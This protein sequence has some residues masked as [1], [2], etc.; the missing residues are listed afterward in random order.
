MSLQ[1]RFLLF[2][3]NCQCP[4]AKDH[5]NT[6]VV[7][8]VAFIIHCG[9]REGTPWGTTEE[10]QEA[11]VEKTCYRIPVALGKLVEDLRK[12]SFAL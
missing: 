7:E 5:Q 4:P 6:L 10:S 12:L 9:K 8:Q 11:G 3:S 2:V 1:E